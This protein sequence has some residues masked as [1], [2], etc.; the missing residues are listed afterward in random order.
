MSLRDRIEAMVLTY[1]Y[2]ADEQGAYKICTDEIIKEIEKRID[3]LDKE[4]P[5]CGALVRVK[6]LLK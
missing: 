6:E 2:H 5:S 3:G 1:G 4:L